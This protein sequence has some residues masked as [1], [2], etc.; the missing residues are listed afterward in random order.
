MEL[1][2]SK[3]KVKVNFALYRP[4]MAQRGSEGIALLLL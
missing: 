4:P 2:Y 1:V 3:V